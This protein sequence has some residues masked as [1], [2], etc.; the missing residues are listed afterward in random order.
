M[1]TAL[2][3]SSEY[4]KYAWFEILNKI[5]FS[6]ALSMSTIKII[7]SRLP[8]QQCRFS[9]CFRIQFYYVRLMHLLSEFKR[10]S[11]DRAVHQE[12]AFLYFG[13]SFE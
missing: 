8:F 7:I 12:S 11:N 3:H 9:C 6:R 4:L 13:A 2:L 1:H 5:L 10:R